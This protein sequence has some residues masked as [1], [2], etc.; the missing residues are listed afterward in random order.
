[1]RKDTHI[2]AMILRQDVDSHA[3]V[4]AAI[5]KGL[6][7][8][9]I[10]DHMPLSCSSAGD[11]IPRGRVKEYCQ[12]VRELGRRYDGQIRILC[13]IEIDYHP[14]VKDEVDAILQEGD[15]DLRLGS[16]HLHVLHDAGWFKTV[17][18]QDYAR[19]MLEN[20]AAAAQTGFFQVIPHIDMY[21]WVFVNSRRFPCKDSVFNEQALLPYVRQTLDAIKRNGVMLEINPHFACGSGSMDD[22]YPSRLIA[23]CA[24][25][26]G[27]RFCYGSDAHRAEDVG[28]MLEQLEQNPLYGEALL[29]HS[30]E[31]TASIIQKTDGVSVF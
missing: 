6:D 8:I 14:S 19:L 16:S 9:A 15:F 18:R 10:T 1:M 28:A 12:K 7:T 20:A 11:R 24:L 23:A 25:A 13:G 21:R 26:S 3:Y 27:V 4:R 31:G 22:V 17:S 29:R 2:H 5:A 30:G